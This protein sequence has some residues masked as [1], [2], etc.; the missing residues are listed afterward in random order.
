MFVSID[1]GDEETFNKI[2]NVSCFEKVVENLKKYSEAQQEGKSCVWSKF[3]IVPDYNDNE[4][5]IMKWY[6]LTT[7]QI[8][9]K[10]VVLDVEREWFKRNDRKI[11]PKMEKMIEM[12][13][14]RCE[15]DGIK[16]DWYESLKCLYGIH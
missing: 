5:E 13:K 2:K 16:L 12:I 9:I 8:G 1:S 15:E 10:A 3:I 11:T 14:N 7:K 4:E 6:D